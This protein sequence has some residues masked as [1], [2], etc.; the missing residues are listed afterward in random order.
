MGSLERKEKKNE[1][2]ERK[3]KNMGDILR[4]LGEE[5]KKTEK[6]GSDR[7]KIEN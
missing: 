7:R 2:P 1:S 6:K 5:K 4:R 3:E